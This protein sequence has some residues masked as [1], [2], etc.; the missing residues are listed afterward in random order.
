MNV[1]EQKSI[2]YDN[3]HLEADKNGGT[4]PEVNSLKRG[5]LNGDTRKTGG[6][7]TEE[8]CEDLSKTEKEIRSHSVIDKI[9]SNCSR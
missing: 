9:L 3:N 5:N 2:F 6:Q 4:G 1:T 7:M 8:P